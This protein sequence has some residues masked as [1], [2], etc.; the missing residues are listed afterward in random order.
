MSNYPDGVSAATID[1]YF[2]EDDSFDAWCVAVADAFSEFPRQ[3]GVTDC[4]PEQYPEA[5][6]AGTT[7]AEFA[8]ERWEYFRDE[9]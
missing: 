3:F 5:F 9:F 6:D 2:A 1:L 7:P 4:N 8:L